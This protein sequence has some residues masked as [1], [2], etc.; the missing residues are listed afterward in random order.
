MLLLFDVY[1]ALLLGVCHSAAA[2]RFHFRTTNQTPL[3]D[4]LEIAELS[5]SGTYNI[6]DS[7]ISMLD[8]FSPCFMSRGDSADWSRSAEEF[9]GVF[10]KL[11]ELAPP[12]SCF[13]NMLLSVLKSCETLTTEE[14][15]NHAVKLT[16]C[17]LAAAHI[18]AP[19]TCTLDILIGQN[20]RACLKDLES[21]PQFWT[22]FS[23][24][25]R[26]IA[27]ICLAE[28]KN[29]EKGKISQIE[30]SR[31]KSDFSQKKSFACT[32]T[33][34]KYRFIYLIFCEIRC[35]RWILQIVRYPTQCRLGLVLLQVLK[36][37]PYL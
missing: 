34:R 18:T 25:F 26:S 30:F 4:E 31:S 16:L 12:P 15:V 36:Q 14:R 37:K 27:T 17:E 1:L 10:T 9:A 32:K 7:V 8:S 35:Q 29:H 28:R 23:G 11:C 20:R 3:D 21:S 19:Q 6:D 33:L 5:S 2:L 24:N 13:R 22:S